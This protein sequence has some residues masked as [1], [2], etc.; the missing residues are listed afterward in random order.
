LAEIGNWGRS[1]QWK[2]ANVCVLIER[3]IILISA[4][5]VLR[6]NG[7]L[8]IAAFHVGSCITC[9]FVTRRNVLLLIRA[10]GCERSL[11]IREQLQGQ[12]I[13][14]LY[15]F[16]NYL[17]KPHLSDEQV[18]SIER[19]L[20]RNMFINIYFQSLS[21]LLAPRYICWGKVVFGFQRI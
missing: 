8:M 3:S 17:L 13:T 1:S 14:N 10:I 4:L 12:G 7:V 11:S 9:T 5:S 21:K 15:T 6:V 18:Q 19:F 2:K 16:A 20:H